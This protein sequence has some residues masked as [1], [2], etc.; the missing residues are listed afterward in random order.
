MY[1]KQCL[2][3]DEIVC[4][5]TKVTDNEHIVTIKSKDLKVLHA[6]VKLKET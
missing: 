4:F 5:Y 6:I 3:G 1:K 2:L